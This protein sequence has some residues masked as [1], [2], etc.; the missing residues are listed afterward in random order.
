MSKEELE[1]WTEEDRAQQ[2]KRRLIM[3]AM[4]LLT[5]AGVL[6]GGLF[7]SPDALLAEDQPQEPVAVVQND[8]ENDLD[9]DG[10]DGGA[11]T[12][13]EA[14]E[15]EEQEEEEARGGVRV[16]LRQKILQLP[17]AVRLTVILPLWALGWLILTGATALWSAVLSPVLGKILGWLILL[18]ALLGAFAFAVKTVFP[19]LPLKKILNK[20]SVLGIAVG[21]AVLA[22]ADI[23]LP[24]FWEDYPR[25]EA[26]LRG[27]G[28]LLVLGGATFAYTRRE[29]KRRL[30]LPAGSPGTE[31]TEP[32]EAAE[33]EEVK[34]PLTREDILA[35]ADE[36]GR[37]RKAGKATE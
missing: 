12:Q 33:A 22:L 3:G 30:A 21:A 4:A 37:D 19:D 24:L 23:L 18:A 13:E 17:Y 11:E 28:I 10:G 29:R 27:G 15:E 36:T 16:G 26:I 1:T 14:G 32:E 2:R 9:G 7:H 35:I 34:K 8:D 5:S 25:I 20:R 31:E 6:V